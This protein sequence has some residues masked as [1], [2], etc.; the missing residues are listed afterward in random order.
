MKVSMN[1]KNY[2][3]ISCCNCELRE[4][5]LT[6]CVDGLCGVLDLLEEDVEPLEHLVVVDRVAH[7]PVDELLVG[8]V[9]LVHGP[10]VLLLV[11]GAHLRRVLADLVEAALEALWK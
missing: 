7:D 2:E 4:K 10:A 3:Y 8:A 11:H 6:L 5:N 9:V 1:T